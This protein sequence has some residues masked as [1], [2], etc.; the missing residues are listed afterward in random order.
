ML[1]VAYFLLSLCTLYIA[2]DTPVVILLLVVLNF[3]NAVRLLKKVPFPKLE[4]GRG[5]IA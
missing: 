1:I 4:N 5:G 2:N 3:A